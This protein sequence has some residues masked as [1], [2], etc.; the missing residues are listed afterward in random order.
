MIRNLDLGEPP[1]GAQHVAGL[2]ADLAPGEVAETEP[3]AERR[4]SSGRATAGGNRATPAKD[5]DRQPAPARSGWGRPV[6]AARPSARAGARRTIMAG[7]A[8]REA[9]PAAIS[10]A[11]TKAG[12]AR[13]ASAPIRASTASI[14]AS[15]PKLPI[16]GRA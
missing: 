5:R 4:R 2:P 12:L 7:R 10:A 13:A 6:A 3:G 14:S 16:R 11:A 1:G 9:A 15:A 8:A